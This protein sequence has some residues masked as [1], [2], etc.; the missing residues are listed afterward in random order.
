MGL[1]NSSTGSTAAFEKG[2]TRTGSEKLVAFA[3]NPNVGKSTVF[4]AL[5]GMRQH[6]GNWSGKTVTNACGSYETE[7]YRYILADIPGTYSLSAR[8]PEEQIARDFICFG[9]SDAVVVVCDTSCLERNLSLVMQTALITPNVIV[10][11]NLIDEAERKGIRIDPERL[12]K[13]LGLPVA[14]VIARKKRTLSALTEAMDS[15]ISGEAPEP[16]GMCIPDPIERA[17]EKVK[18]AVDDA[19]GKDYINRWLALKLIYCEAS[20]RAKLNEVY[21]DRLFGNEKVRSAVKAARDELL[22]DGIGEEEYGNMLSAGAVLA[23][24]EAAAE[25]TAERGAP[26]SA[27]DR[28]ADK[29]VTGKFLAF[30]VMLLML[31]MILWITIV[32]ANYPS[33]LLSA[34]AFWLEGRL[35]ELFALAKLPDRLADAAVTGVFRVLGWVVSVMLPPM[36]IFFPLFTILEDAGFLPRI[37]YNLDRPFCRCDACGKQ[38]LTMCMGLGCNAAGVIGCRIIDSPRE[39]LLAILTN[40]YVPCNGRF[41]ALLSVITMFF[42][43][44]A[45]GLAASA[46]S[47]LCLTATILTGIAA[48]FA[49]T[50]LLSKTVLRG[51]PSSFTLELPSYRLPKFG[52]TLV[53]SVFERTLF[54]LGR[55]ALV[56][57]PAGLIIWLAANVTVHGSTVL[58]I[59][60]SFLDPVGRLMGLDGVILIAFIL[61]FPANEIV[62]PITI[63]AYTAQSGLIELESIEQLKSVFISNGWTPLTAVCFIIFLLMHW[64]CSTTLLTIKKETGSLKYTALSALLPTVSG[65]AICVLINLFADLIAG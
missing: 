5:T 19:L 31:G 15:L 10:C 59:C 13:A 6:T 29:I 50:G 28:A 41:P 35:S 65:F 7:K 3:G 64:P 47:A 46:I 57:A 63:M 2:L 33:Q 36:A 25:A 58:D 24:E 9:G 18:E 22:L 48:T 12:S 60:S 27:F 30:P 39:R 49:A 42:I 45:G 37:A 34:G 53:R 44:S 54:V 8:S 21:G 52:E 55:A 62:I 43:G 51:E 17:A 26:Y 4:N 23:A 14:A 40:C 38:A 61:G 11:L 56:A 20:L 16:R 32:G 1:T